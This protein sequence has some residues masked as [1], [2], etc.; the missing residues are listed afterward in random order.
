MIH[1]QIIENANT[2]LR[3]KNLEIIAGI[4][5]A[6]VLKYS[7]SLCEIEERFKKLCSSISF[8]VNWDIITANYD[9][10][11]DT[12]ADELIKIRNENKGDS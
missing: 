7:N 5:L 3:K 11:C 4:Y 9:I 2:A 6:F 8:P 10:Y 12:L 1:K